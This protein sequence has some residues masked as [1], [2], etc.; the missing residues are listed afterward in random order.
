MRRQLFVCLPMTAY[1][2]LREFPPPCS[3]LIPTS[4][5]T[6]SDSISQINSHLYDSFVS[7]ESL[8]RGS[9]DSLFLLN[10]R[11]IPFFLSAK[12][13]PELPALLTDNDFDL[14]LASYLSTSSSLT[15]LSILLY[16]ISAF[17]HDF[18][19]RLPVEVMEQVLALFEQL[20][21]SD[22][23]PVGERI[24]EYILLIVSAGMTMS[25]GVLPKRFYEAL[26]AFYGKSPEIDKQIAKIA[27]DAAPLL[28]KSEALR[29][30]VIAFVAGFFD[31]NISDELSQI[32]YVLAVYFPVLFED[33][34]V[35]AVFLKL[36]RFPEQRLSLFRTIQVVENVEVVFGHLVDEDTAGILRDAFQDPSLAPA[37]LK[38]IRN[39]LRLDGPRTGEIFLDREKSPHCILA[40]L[41]VMVRE[42]AFRI[43]R[44]A[45]WLL[46][47]AVQWCPE[48]G[49]S[50]VEE[51]L[52]GIIK[53]IGVALEMGAEEQ[54]IA[55]A[56]LPTLRELCLDQKKES[57]LV[58][59]VMECGIGK[60]VMELVE[61][62]DDDVRETAV[63]VARALFAEEL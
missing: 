59:V 58:N 53:V 31:V 2:S 38:A 10:S 51:N 49:R 6:S 36:R 35:V 39:L 44:E 37:A 28:E 48:V 15:E 60:K 24:L 8:L 54:F 46:L 22:F 3:R 45:V 16:G 52:E 34:S 56:T 61:S 12:H 43:Q 42:A 27:A 14:R 57:E 18:P 5:L 25:A 32:V 9:T 40:E 13:Y 7:F 41:Y 47:E 17:F 21:P 33:E 11:I 29:D 4:L 62:D 50:E 26:L 20:D 30:F 55:I 1:K 23:P 19:D 63:D